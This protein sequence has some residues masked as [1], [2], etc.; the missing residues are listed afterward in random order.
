MLIR[1]SGELVLVVDDDAAMREFLCALLEQSGYRTCEAANGEEVRD[2][3]RRRRP[4]LV[5]LDVHLP[6]ISGYEVC[7]DLRQEYGDALPIIFVSGERV[8]SFD[9]V[10]GLLIGGDDYVA[11]P[12]APDELVAR[13]R[14][15]IRRSRSLP[16]AEWVDLTPRELDVMRMLAG[17]SDQREIAAQFSIAPR[18][19]AKHIEHI[20]H[21]LG[22]HSRAQAVV[23]AYRAGVL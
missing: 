15:L 19:V 17:G 10:A 16:A 8:E 13:V 6:G 11:K 23:A 4:R 2:V 9:R 21:K 14:G 7:R 18:T 3:V 20:L 22:V 1:E 12:F 5:L